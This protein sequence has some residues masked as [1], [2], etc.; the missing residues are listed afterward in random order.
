MPLWSTFALVGLGGA[1]GSML[2]WAVGLWASQRFGPGFPYGTLI[3]NLTGS[4]AIGVLAEIAAGSGVGV[5]HP[6]RVFAI[7][8]VLGGFTTF[9]ALSYETLVLGRT[10]PLTALVYAAGSVIAGL[11]CAALGTAIVKAIPGR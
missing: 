1:L 6:L 9:S 4:L 11:A 2:R 8:G 10:S 7:V 5:A 3:V